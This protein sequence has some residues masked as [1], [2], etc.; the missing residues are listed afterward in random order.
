MNFI[1]KFI[2]CSLWKLTSPIKLILG[3][4]IAISGPALAAQS[5]LSI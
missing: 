4:L 3:A 5:M 2:G 1:E